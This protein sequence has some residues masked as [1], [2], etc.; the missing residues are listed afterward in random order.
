MDGRDSARSYL[1]LFFVSLLNTV[2]HKRK[3]TFKKKK[4]SNY[5][6]R[7]LLGIVH[8]DHEK[9]RGMYVL[10]PQHKRKAVKTTC[11]ASI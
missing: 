10:A 3:H 9:E 1:T 6:G 4:I 7:L 8:Y 5:K 2:N 11:H